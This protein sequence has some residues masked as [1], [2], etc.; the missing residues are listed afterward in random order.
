MKF[1]VK[2][3]KSNFYMMTFVLVLC[4]VTCIFWIYLNKYVIGVIYLIVT[5]I[6]AHMYY[7]STYIIDNN[8]LTI[9]LGFL[10][11]KIKCSNI[12]KIEQEDDRV[13]LEFAK[14]SLSL[15]PMNKELF[16]TSLKKELKTKGE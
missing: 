16:V 8:V 11:V 1:K 7:F 2:P 15:Y 4:F 9:K 10:P 6:L 13:K 3:N 5:V 12:K 14:L